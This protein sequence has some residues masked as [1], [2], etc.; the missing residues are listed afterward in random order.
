MSTTT[1]VNEII[2]LLTAGPVLPGGVNEQYNVCG[3][4]N[5]RCKDEAN[6]RKHGP[7]IQLSYTISG[8]SST[9]RISPKDAVG[10]GRAVERF[11]R[12]KKLVNQLGLEYG[13]EVR[14]GG[15]SAA[16]S[17]VPAGGAESQS[18][19][20]PSLE[21]KRLM[22][23]Q[24]SWKRKALAR[25]KLL[26]SNRVRIR[27]LEASR[28]K[29]REEALQRRKESAEKQRQLALAEKSIDV[30]N[31]KVAEL[32]AAVKKTVRKEG[33]RSR[34]E[35]KQDAGTTTSSSDRPAPTASPTA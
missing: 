13:K 2:G 22:R 30:L 21:R 23:S 33:R 25:Q 28:S 35:G 18:V 31:R 29:W 24:A 20:A 12:L 15:F 6:P 3:K 5:C 19:S 7:Y 9:L 16:K 10:V 4:K 32:E 14:K 11:K 34:A 27:D 26:L 1:T 8:Q 17:C